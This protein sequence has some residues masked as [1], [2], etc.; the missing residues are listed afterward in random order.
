MLFDINCTKINQ[1]QSMSR[2]IFLCIAYYM[3]QYW[4]FIVPYCCAYFCIYSVNHGR[5]QTLPSIFTAIVASGERLGESNAWK[6]PELI[7][8]VR[9]PRY[10][11]P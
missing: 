10:K 8:V 1:S 3:R 9:L 6:S 11:L 5:K 7:F 4:I 2:E